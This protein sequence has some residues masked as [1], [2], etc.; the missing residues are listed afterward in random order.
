M[1]EERLLKGKTALITG[2]ARGIGRAVARLL[3][4]SGA[5]VVACARRPSPEFD[6]LCA[7]LAEEA[8]VS[9]RPLCFDLTEP[10][11]IKA[12]VKEL[13]SWRCPV[14]ILVNNAG[15]PHGGLFQMTP[16]EQV[17]GNFESNFFGPLALTQS[18]VRLMARRRSGSLVNIAS[19]AG[20]DGRAGNVAYGTGKAA[21]VLATRVLARELAPLGLRVNAVAPGAIETDMLARM[22]PA[23]RE[24]LI[25]DN[26]LKRPG[27][28]E[29]VAQAVLFLAS[30]A[31]SYITGQVLRVD[32]GL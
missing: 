11:Q 25:N 24:R 16:L 7:A 30:E 4:A 21:L 26:A 1:A 14:D 19:A 8:R 29:E 18:L 12:A 9:V 10:D 23:A 6:G 2:C 13:A 27:R 15:E 31:S 17:R 32:G 5:D 3:A 28:P 22:D 20:L